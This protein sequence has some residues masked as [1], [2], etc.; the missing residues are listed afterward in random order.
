MGLHV[1]F[2]PQ[3]VSQAA[4]DQ[5]RR[6]VVVCGVSHPVVAVVVHRWLL[7]C[8]GALLLFYLHVRQL[9]HLCEFTCGLL[10]R[11]VILLLFGLR[12]AMLCLRVVLIN[13][14]R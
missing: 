11:F 9:P 1:L 10:S 7:A 8:G 4:G 3:I 14:F 13:C 12:A 2:P 5:V 6:T